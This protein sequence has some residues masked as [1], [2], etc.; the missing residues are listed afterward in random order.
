MV[1]V[2]GVDGQRQDVSGTLGWAYDRD[3]RATGRLGLRCF[4][5]AD[6]AE[7]RRFFLGLCFIVVEMTAC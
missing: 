3:G 4:L 2:K 7:Y 1:N 6:Y 5:T